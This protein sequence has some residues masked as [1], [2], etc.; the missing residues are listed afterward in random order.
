MSNCI[1][2]L[3]TQAA[4]VHN[5][6]PLSILDFPGRNRRGQ[7]H[8]NLRMVLMLVFLRSTLDFDHRWTPEVFKVSEASL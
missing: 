2:H 4:V 8:P 6:S 1:R 5:L 3:K 7:K